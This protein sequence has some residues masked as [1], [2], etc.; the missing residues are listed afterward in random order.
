[1]NERQADIQTDRQT[2]RHADKNKSEETRIKKGRLCQQKR[3]QDVKKRWEQ[4]GNKKIDT[5]IRKTDK[6]AQTIRKTM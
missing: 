6:L 2:D 4:K 5:T 3:R 1:M